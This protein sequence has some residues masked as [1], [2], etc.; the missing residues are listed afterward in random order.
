MSSWSG[1]RKFFYSSIFFTLIIAVAVPLFYFV[2][3]DRPTC[4]DGKRNGDEQEVD[5]GGSCEKICQFQSKNV[6]ILW[7]RAFEVSLGVYNLATYI[8]NPNLDLKAEDVPYVFRLFDDKNLLVAE[9]K[10]RANIPPQ[11]S[12]VIF[13]PNITTGNRNVK[14]VFFD[15]ETDPLWREVPQDELPENILKVKTQQ[16]SKNQT[17]LKLEVEIENVSF[18]RVS[19]ID[20]TAILYDRE[21]N[22]I[23]ISKT[24]IDVI[25]GEGVEKAVFTW[26]NLDPLD[27]SRS[28][29]I[30]V[31]R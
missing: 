19:N 20:T 7:S 11:S 12:F 21:G 29:I 28:E 10:G 2:F 6:S 14:R 23:E 17:S 25:E 1:K 9:K 15:F 22:V 26:P 3:Y 30:P 16:I 8:E 24:V 31:V 27:I 18:D 13:E 4:F 5:C